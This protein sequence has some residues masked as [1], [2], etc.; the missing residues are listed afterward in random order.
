MK[1]TLKKYIF[2]LSI[3]NIWSFETI[4]QVYCFIS[5]LHQDSHCLRSEIYYHFI[6]YICM[7]IYIYKYNI[8]KNH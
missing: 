2:L 4:Y 7:Y 5:S 6:F 3:L 8:C 1:Y